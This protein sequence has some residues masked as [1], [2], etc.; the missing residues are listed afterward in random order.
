MKQNGIPPEAGAADQLQH[1]LLSF[2]DI[3]V[4]K[5][6]MSGQNQFHR[7]ICCKRHVC[8]FIRGFVGIDTAEISCS[9]NN[10]AVPC[11]FGLCQN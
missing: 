11:L 6:H 8:E 2:H 3:S 7:A 9:Y 10:R 4:I 5:M 1:L